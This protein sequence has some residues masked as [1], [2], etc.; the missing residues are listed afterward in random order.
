MRLSDKTKSK[1]KT[2]YRVL[3]GGVPASLIEG[4]SNDD[5][6]V[7][8]KYGNI[9][10]VFLTE[11]SASNAIKRTLE[12]AE[13]AR[14]SMMPEWPKFNNLYEATRAIPVVEPFDV[15]LQDCDNE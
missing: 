9:P 13:K 14:N 4:Y 2:Y 7:P 12:A 5:V 8:A 11:R 6:V 3:I 10:A 1:T 15:P